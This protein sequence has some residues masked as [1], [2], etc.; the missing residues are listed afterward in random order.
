[1]GESVERK[2]KTRQNKPEKPAPRTNKELEDR[3][4][5]DTNNNGH[6]DT[7]IQRKTLAR[8]RAARAERLKE[9]KVQKIGG[10]KAPQPLDDVAA[11]VEHVFAALREGTRGPNAESI[12]PASDDHAEADWYD[13]EK[14]EYHGKALEKAWVQLLIRMYA[15]SDARRP[16]RE[17]E[18]TQ[19][20]RILCARRPSEVATLANEFKQLED[21][22][23]VPRQSKSSGTNHVPDNEGVADEYPPGYGGDE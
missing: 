5:W 13:L 23:K 14:D 16:D 21:Q 9:K 15:I 2:G 4:L 20:I 11:D 19:Q 17:W 1:M 3:E 22:Y 12:A 8:L 18:E 7:D 6:D 10:E